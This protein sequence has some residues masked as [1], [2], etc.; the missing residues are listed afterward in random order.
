MNRRICVGEVRSPTSKKIVSYRKVHKITF[1]DFQL[2]YYLTTSIYVRQV[3]PSYSLPS[4]YHV[5]KLIMWYFLTN[6][7]SFDV[8]VHTQIRKIAK[9]H[10]WIVFIFN[11]KTLEKQGMKM[12]VFLDFCW[13]TKFP[14]THRACCIWFFGKVSETFRSKLENI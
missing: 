3:W 4:P 8:T 7:E 6:F 5:L 14:D 13:R 12:S 2:E 10:S 11:V 1:G 9:V